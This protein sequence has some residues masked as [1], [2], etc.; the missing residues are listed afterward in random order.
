[1]ITTS[2][3]VASVAAALTKAQGR[4]GPV[5]KNKT[6][7]H[8]KS[9]YADL[10]SIFDATL[11]A[12]RDNGLLLIQS[13]GKA[14]MGITVNTRIIHESG[15]W[16]DFGETVLP[17]EKSN[18]QAVGG[19]LTY[20]KRYSLAAALCVFADDDDDANGAGVNKPS[21]KE[22]AAALKARKQGGGSDDG[23][24]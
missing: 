22:A 3:T 19:A 11:P 8:L 21:G 7:P 6:N 10:G 20:C 18:P 9:A 2:E 1:M 14:E 15:E 12:L 17:V 4:F 24:L 5:L 23:F 13:C 16:I